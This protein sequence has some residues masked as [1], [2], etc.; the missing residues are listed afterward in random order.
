MGD[1]LSEE[2]KREQAPFDIL[3]TLRAFRR[4]ASAVEVQDC[5]HDLQN[6][7]ETTVL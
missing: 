4:G 1:Q 2:W 7:Q 6:C 5:E 3:F